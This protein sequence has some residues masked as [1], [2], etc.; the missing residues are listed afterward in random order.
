[1]ITVWKNAL[2]LEEII[3]KP[4]RSLSYPNGIWTIDADNALRDIG[5]VAT[6]T[7]E[8]KMIRGG[9]L[10]AGRYNRPST[11]SAQ[12]VIER[13]TQKDLKQNGKWQTVSPTPSAPTQTT[14]AADMNELKEQIYIQTASIQQMLVQ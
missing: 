5:F 14:Y 11:A 4:V 9:K 13:A 10:P 8:E 2:F 3:G 12:A 1:M 7:S 6:F